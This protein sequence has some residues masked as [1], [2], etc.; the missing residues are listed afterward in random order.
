MKHTLLLGAA[1][2]AGLATAAIDPAAAAKAALAHAG[3]AK[4]AE[5]ALYVA[6][7]RDDGRV[8]YEVRFHDGVNAYDYEI[9]PA[10][11]AVLESKREAL[12]ALPAAAPATP[13]APDIAR[14]KAIAL[15][16]AKVAEADAK[17]LRAKRDF[18]DGRAI[19][20]VEFRVGKMEYEY[21]IDAATG[22]ILK[23]DIDRDDDWF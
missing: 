2:A 20:E 10:D 21:D 11:G 22:A 12:P 23:R 14:A 8:V 15:A 18:D 17:R 13:A 9:D 19:F 3:V 16:D 4:P 1:L 6:P 5:H 7:D